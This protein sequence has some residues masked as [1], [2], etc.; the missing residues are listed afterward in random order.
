MMNEENNEELH[1]DKLNK[2]IKDKKELKF[3]RTENE[4]IKK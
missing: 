4:N 2:Q 1:I 3:I